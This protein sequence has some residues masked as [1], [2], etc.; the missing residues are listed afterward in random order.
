MN[1]TGNNF[2]TLRQIR[3]THGWKRNYEKYLPLS[4]F[5]FRP[6]GFLL[7]WISI[8]LGL[9]TEAVAWLSGIVGIIGCALLVFGSERLLPVG[10]GLLLFFNLLD[11]V[12]GSIARTTKTENPYGRFLD[13][14]CGGIVDFVFWAIIG[15]AAYQHPRY[16]IWPNPLYLDKL[17]WIAMGGII[18]FLSIWLNYLEQTFDK[19]LRPYWDKIQ[20]NTINESTRN[21]QYFHKSYG[22][23]TKNIIN[24]VRIINNNLRVRESHYFLILI[25]FCLDIIDILLFFYLSYYLFHTVTSMIIYFIRGVKIKNNLNKLQNE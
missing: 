20:A 13:S 7:T 9:S 2:P 10:L 15:I 18:C 25:A 16:L 1:K 3:E 19:L 24:T 11:C 4:R 23:K 22:Y 14:I 6:A 21:Q 17:F 5:V 12:D 8:R